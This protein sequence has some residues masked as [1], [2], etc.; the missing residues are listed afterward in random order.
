MIVRVFRESNYARYAPARTCSRASTLR[1][2]RVVRVRV[3]AASGKDNT[4]DREILFCGN[5]IVIFIYRP[6]VVRP[7][8]FPDDSLVDP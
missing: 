5:V 7:R 1:Y 4:L 8:L 6:L 2:T 3:R